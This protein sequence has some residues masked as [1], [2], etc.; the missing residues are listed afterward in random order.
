[1]PR[2]PPGHDRKLVALGKG[3]HAPDIRGDIPRN[4]LRGNVVRVVREQTQAQHTTGRHVFPRP[5]KDR[6]D[7]LCSWLGLD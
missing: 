7:R 6:Q 5:Q 1:M 4:N 3:N 2:S